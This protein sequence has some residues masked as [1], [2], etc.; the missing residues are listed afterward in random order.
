MSLPTDLD[1]TMPVEHPEYGAGDIIQV[2]RN[3][4][5]HSKTWLLVFF[6]N[7]AL[8][9]SQTIQ[10]DSHSVANPRLSIVVDG[11]VTCRFVHSALR[12]SVTVDITDP[13][14]PVVT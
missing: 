14:S 5:D 6:R 1:V 7:P 13:E 11:K 10:V 12:W 4:E 9:G 8:D 2:Y 3:D